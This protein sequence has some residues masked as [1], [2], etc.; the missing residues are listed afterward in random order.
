[1]FDQFY[2]LIGKHMDVKRFCSHRLTYGPYD[3]EV[4]GNTAPDVSLGVNETGY[5]APTHIL[6][7]HLF[8]VIQNRLFQVSL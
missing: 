1:M 3:M 7:C 4:T 2:S 8:E 6:F 5:T